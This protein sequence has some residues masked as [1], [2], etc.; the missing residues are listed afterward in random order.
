MIARERYQCRAKRDFNGD[1]KRLLACNAPP[2]MTA[3]RERLNVTAALTAAGLWGEP[4]AA[5]KAQGVT[6]RSRFAR[7]PRRLVKHFEAGT[8][9]FPLGFKDELASI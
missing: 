9:G 2:D 4:A 7:R 3:W 6:L 5:S 8:L 1:G